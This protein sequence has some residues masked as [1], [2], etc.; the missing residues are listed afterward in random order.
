MMLRG[1]V[2][3]KLSHLLAEERYVVVEFVGF[4]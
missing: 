1:A 3:V 2:K 4:I